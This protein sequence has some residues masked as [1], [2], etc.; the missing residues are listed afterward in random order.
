MNI[1]HILCLL[2]AFAVVSPVM[3]KAKPVKGK[4]VKIS[5]EQ[6]VVKIKGEEKTYTIT[7][8]TKILNKDGEE[9][10]AGDAKFKMVELTVDPDDESKAKEIKEAAAKSKSK[11]KK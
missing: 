7:E 3:A 5:T 9:V 1:K 4:M 10:A 8:D 2:I 6:V 11:K